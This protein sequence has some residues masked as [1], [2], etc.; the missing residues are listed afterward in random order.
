MFT[1]ALFCAIIVIVNKGET[2]QFIATI[3]V[4]QLISNKFDLVCY[5]LFRFEN[6]NIIFGGV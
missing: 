1:C 5:F 3:R 6:G 4:N 2:K